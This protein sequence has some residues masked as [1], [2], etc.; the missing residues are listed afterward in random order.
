MLRTL[1]LVIA[2]ALGAAREEDPLRE[3]KRLAA[4]GRRLVQAHRAY[5]PPHAVAAVARHGAAVAKVEA[6][7][8]RDVGA[9]RRLHGALRSAERRARSALSRGGGQ[10]GNQN[11]Q[12]TFN[13]V[14][15]ERIRREG[16]ARPRD[17][18]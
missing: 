15:F 13:M 4:K 16:S 17:L 5:A 2:S 7:Y 18:A 8:A 1:L 6:A 9:A 10:C 11:V 12:D 14:Q 3:S